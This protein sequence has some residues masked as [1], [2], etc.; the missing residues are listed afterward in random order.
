MTSKF[1]APWHKASFQRF[2]N[3]GFPQLLS[4]CLPLIGYQVRSTGQYT[5]SL[6]LTLASSPADISI[7]YTD[8]PQPDDEGIFQI[9]GKPCVVVPYASS[10]DLAGA[11]CFCAGEQLMDYFQQRLSYQ[12]PSEI[13]WTVELLR[14]WLP[15]D[16]WM[17]EFF[18]PGATYNGWRALVQPLDQ[19]NWLATHEHLRR[20]YVKDRTHLFTPGHFGRTCPFE[21]PEGPNIAR[22]LVIAVGAEIREGRLVVVDEQPASSLGLAA[23]MIPLLEHDQPRMLLM[24]TNM[25]RQ[26]LTPP[27]PEPA[28][29]QSG[30]ESPESWCGRNLLTA[31]VSWGLDTFDEGIVISESCAHRLNYPQP[32]APGDK[33]SNR[34]GTKGVVSRILPDDEMPHLSDGTPVELVCNFIRQHVRQNFG[35]IR[36]ALLGRIAHQEG[37]PVIA[38]PFLAP[39]EEQIRA[40][41][42]ASGL[43]LD[44]METLTSGRN[45][46]PLAQ[47]SAVGWVYWGR[48]VHIAS[49]KLTMPGQGYPQR[50]TALEYY[51]LRDAGTF[52]LL[53][54]FLTTGVVEHDGLQVERLSASAQESVVSP[55][56]S[57]LAQRLAALG[58]AVERVDDQLSFG[59]IPPDG[60][61]LHLAQ[62]VPHPWLR[63]YQLTQIGAYPVCRAL[64]EYAVLEEVN[65]RLSRMLASHA[66][67]SLIRPAY[68]RLVTRVQAFGDALLTPAHLHFEVRVPTSGRAVVTPGAGLRY[69]QVGLPEAMAWELFS[70]LL[71]QEL[72][73][74]EMGSSRAVQAL[75][76][77]MARSWVLVHRAPS[78][79]PRSFIACHPV[80]D[81]QSVIRLHPFTSRLLQAD[82]DGDQAAIFLP[83]TP[84]AQQ[85]AGERLSLPGQLAANPD[86]LKAL[87][88]T[89]E[90]LWG[91]AYL[92]LS[93]EGRSELAALLPTE[94]PQTDIPLTHERLT[95]A[96]QSLLQEQGSLHTLVVLEQLFARGLAAAQRSGASISPFIGA[97]SYAT[98]EGHES[99]VWQRYLEELEEQL[100]TRSDYTQPDLGPQLLA[101]KSGA[102][103]D[104]RHLIG[105]VAAQG[106]VKDINEEPV[107]IRHGYREGLSPRELYA[108]AVG[109]R[110]SF[111]LVLR[112]LE[113]LAR[114]MHASHSS[115]SFHVLARAMRSSSPG[116][117]FAH[118]AS[119]SERDPL[120]DLDSRLFV[121]LPIA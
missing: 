119:L 94:L 45:G 31:F 48:L 26:W 67:E 113:A 38:P 93:D 27:T 1:S 71:A 9:D 77:L 102:Q 52:E 57:D 64:P 115:R 70:P 92:S 66:P 120:T 72:G 116:I 16:T 3:E 59:L 78:I 43:P 33:L 42:S 104:L 88:P 20:L 82:F 79:G 100:A 7:E 101:I 80:R 108:L 25:M 117:V 37:Q 95:V 68:A 86:L 47:A 46:A 75:D 50:L 112:E 2:L 56:F 41:L 34:H 49:D 96:L 19:T 63:D 17:R 28:L 98:P 4:D 15:V 73:E 81:P 24:G 58:V 18:T 8:L 87:L 32:V 97:G 109:A 53:R 121:G 14:A 6:H 61:T 39:A 83:L 89:D 12:A 51:A 11:T 29:V 60:E 110:E 118:A 23:S 91:L 74:E 69:D 114:D 55:L 111:A 65:T 107:A 76:A 54:E 85:E 10:D 106:V 22:I 84:E 44:G 5:Y 40:R 36:E 99:Q 13:P 90:V 62:A 105:L 103:G 30:N 35:E 21:T